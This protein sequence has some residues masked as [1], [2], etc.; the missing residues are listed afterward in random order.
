[1]VAAVRRVD[2][3]T[4]REAA[5]DVVDALFVPAARID[6]RQLAQV[7]A[8]RDDPGPVGDGQRRQ[9]GHAAWRRTSQNGGRRAVRIGIEAADPLVEG[10]ELLGSDG[11]GE[12]RLQAVLDT[13]VVTG[14]SGTH[15]PG[16]DPGRRAP[17]RGR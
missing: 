13:D 4:L 8:A 9:I 16:R 2:A 5:P 17:D 6:D 14:L 1:V 7:L 15:A 3:G 12:Q 10:D 11:A